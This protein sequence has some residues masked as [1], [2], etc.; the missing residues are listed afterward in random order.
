MSPIEQLIAT[1]T[2]LRASAIAAGQRVTFA[3]VNGAKMRQ[4]RALECEHRAAWQTFY[5]ADATL[6]A[7]INREVA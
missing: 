5:A 6:H 4:I 7:L 2:T 1:C 3:T